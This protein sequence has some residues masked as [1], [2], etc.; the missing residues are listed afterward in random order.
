MDRQ[1]HHAN[2]Q[3]EFHEKQNH[4]KVCAN[5]AKLAN[6]GKLANLAETSRNEKPAQSQSKLI[7]V[8]QVGSLDRGCKWLW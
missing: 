3:A 8:E 6:Q 2:L 5:L 7:K 1:N 4:E